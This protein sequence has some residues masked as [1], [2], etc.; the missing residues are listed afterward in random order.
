MSN[1]KT[2]AGGW[3]FA[4][5]RTLW[6][7]RFI[8]PSLPTLLFCVMIGAAGFAPAGGRGA[9]WA[10]VRDS[11]HRAEVTDAQI[12]ELIGKL[13]HPSYETRARATRCLCMIG[14]R[15]ADSEEFETALRARSLLQ[16]IESVYFG[17]CSIHLAAEKARIAW[18]EPTDLIITIRNQ[19][20]YRAQLPLDTSAERRR[21]LSEQA[22]QVGDMVDLADYL[23]VTAPE[24]RR[25]ELRADDLQGD[26]QVADAVEWRA[27]GGPVGE[28][29]AGGEVIH[30]LRPLN[31]GWAR[32]PLLQRGVY[33]I[34]FDYDPQWDDE[35]FRRAGVGRVTSNVLEVEVTKAAPPI[36]S[37]SGGSRRPAVITAER[38]GARLIARL[39]NADDLPIWVNLNLGA[40][41]PPFAQL[42]WTILAGGSREEVRF[43]LLSPQPSL[44]A[45]TQ[46]RFRKLAPGESVE[47]GR[48]PLARFMQ[49]PGV[50]ALPA[51]ADFELQA[52][53]VNQAGI[54]W[55]RSPSSGSLLGNPRAPEALRN[56]LPRRMIT[57]RFTSNPI[58]LTKG[59]PQPASEP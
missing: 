59:D 28:L 39:T 18:D 29:P 56:P 57:G 9:A 51:G 2:A 22:R 43:D 10:E 50:Q 16:V 26:P 38:E 42:V 11:C 8:M 21:A 47:L 55:Q 37:A 54:A 58:E 35:E 33:K 15:A 41:Q 32:Y 36:V 20:A 27:E 44:E 3:L 1:R 25:V 5:F 12:Q 6:V 53:L 48:A 45:F 49:A 4:G 30:R 46:E 19:S 17:G 34:L 40:D 52:V 7:L 24:G 13:G 23:R 31:R 14:Q